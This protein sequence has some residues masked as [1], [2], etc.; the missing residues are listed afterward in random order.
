MKT[1]VKLKYLSIGRLLM[2]M[3]LPNMLFLFASI[4]IPPVV[5]IAIGNSLLAALSFGVCIA[6]SNIMLLIFFDDS[7]DFRIAD[8][9]S[10][11]I[12][13]SWAGL[14]ART[15]WSVIWRYSGQ[16]ESWTNS[17][18]IAYFIFMSVCAA[19]FHLAAPG[20]VDDRIP[21]KYWVKIGALCAMGLLALIFSTWFLGLV[22]LTSTQ[23]EN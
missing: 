2:F 21:T 13:C 4:A 20:A 1:R 6:Y 7:D 22:P 8:Y 16:P 23:L 19:I 14:F 12:F 3:L 15:S 9:L 11:G 5:L 17:P 10:L 18:F